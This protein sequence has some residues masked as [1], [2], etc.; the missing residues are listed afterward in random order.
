MWARDFGQAEIGRCD[1]QKQGL[2]FGHEAMPAQML[3]ARLVGD[4]FEKRV[5]KLQPPLR[6]R[7]FAQGLLKDL[8]HE[9][10]VP[11]R[12]LFLVNLSENR[13]EF[14]MPI[15]YLAQQFVQKSVVNAWCWLSH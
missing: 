15:Q 14:G 4:L 9:G 1:F 2:L 11:A 13:S 8:G 12:L 5:A 10:G 3:L 7:F 6:I